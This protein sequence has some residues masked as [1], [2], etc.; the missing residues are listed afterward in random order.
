MVSGEVKLVVGETV[1]ETIQS[2]DLFGEGAF[3]HEDGLHSETAIAKTDCTLAFLDKRR[4][5][6][7]VQQTPMFAIEVMRSY[8]DRLRKFKQSAQ[9]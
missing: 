6:F 4:F 1:T 2:G 5:L 9:R 3:V 8:S 7:A